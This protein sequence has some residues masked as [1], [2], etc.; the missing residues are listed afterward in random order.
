LKAA[1]H[2]AL[3]GLLAVT[4]MRLGEAIALEP[5]D[6][7]LTTASSRSAHT[8]PSWSAHGWVPLHP[9]TVE[10]LERYAKA[11]AGLCPRPRASTF[12]LSSIGT[13][14]DRSEVAKT[15]RKLTTAL[16]LRTD[17]VHPTA[18]HLRH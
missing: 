6:V 7:D 11:R 16:G 12:L 14:L 5:D 9:T 4:G 3:F 18:H 15:L 13:S 17:T 10:A 8:P 2:E 1:S